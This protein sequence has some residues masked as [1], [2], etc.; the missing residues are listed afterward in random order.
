MLEKDD[1]KK[2]CK[3]APRVTQSWEAKIV[4]SIPSQHIQESTSETRNQCFSLFLSLS[5][6]SKIIV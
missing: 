1:V 4:G 6:L 5:P 3:K 2:Y